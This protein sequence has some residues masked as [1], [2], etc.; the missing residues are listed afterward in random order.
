MKNAILLVAILMIAGHSYAQVTTSAM[1][2]TVLD[3]EGEA[4]IGATVV[5]IHDPSGTTYGTTT[6]DDG[7]YTLPNLRVG[8]PYT[9]QVSYIG[10]ETN[11]ASDIFLTLGEKESYDFILETEAAVLD[12]VVI[13][14]SEGTIIG[15]DRTGA[16]TNIS[17]DEI[18]KLPTISRSASDYTRLTPASDGNSFAGRNDQ[19]NNF[20]LD[21]SIF[22]N[23]F[24]LDAAAPG[25][26][27]SAQP[28]SLDAIDQ[29]SV[30]IA[31]YDIT[32]AG[33]TG[34]SVNAVTKSGTNTLT[35]TVYGYWRNQGLTG[36]KVED[37]DIPDADLDQLQAGF[38]LGGPL[39]KNKLFFFV[40]GEI[41]R[42]SDLGTTWVPSGS[43]TDGQVSRVKF[44]DMQ[45]VSD[46][47]FNR[48]GYE[49]GAF[50][51]YI[52]ETNSFKGIL[53]L[54]WAISDR[55]TLSAT[56]NFLDAS[57][58][59]PA[60]PSAIAR[61]GP[62]AQTLQMENSG[63]Q[64]NNVIH[65]GILELRSVFGNRFSNKLQVGYTAFRDSRD[66]F[67]EPFPDL[68]VLEAGTPYLVSGHEPFSIH[69]R[70]N[71]DVFQ[72]TNNFSIY[73]GDHTITVGTSVEAFMFD[74]SFNLGVYGGTF[75]P[76]YGSVQ[77]LL[78]SI[79][80]GAL[81]AAVQGARDLFEANGGD[82]GELGEGWALAETNVGQFALY[83]QDEWQATDDFTLTYGVRMDMPLFFNTADKIQ[84]NIDRNCCYDPDIVWSDE[85]GNPVQYT[86]T[87][88][89][90]QTP[91]ISP[92]IG[93]NWDVNGMGKTQLRGG[94]G[95]FT[96]RFPFV[97]IGNQVANPNFFFYNYTDRDFKFPQVWR[98]NLGVDH[99]FGKGWTATV[100]LIYTKDLQ[101]PFVQNHGLRPPT[102]TL[103]DVDNR[104]VY[105]AADRVMHFGAPVNAYVF[106]NTDLGNS[107]SAGFQVRKTWDSDFSVMIGYNYLNAMD[108]TSI[109]AEISSD[110]YDRNPALGHVNT[111]VL[112]PSLYGARHRI[113][114]SAYKTFRY[115]NE[116][117]IS[118]TISAFFQYQQGGT[119][120]DDNLA[121][122]RF[123]YVYAGDINNDGGFNNDI[124][125]IPTD[126]ELDQMNFV[127]DEQREAFRDY[128]EQDEYLSENRGEYAEKYGILAPWW[129]QWDIKIIQ[130]F[131]FGGSPRNN[132]IQI[133]FDIIN[134]GN[135]ISSSWGVKQLPNTSQPVGVSV[136][137]ATL[138][139]TYSFDPDGP[140][141]TFSPD[142]S[143]LSRWQGQLG[144]RYI[145]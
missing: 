88:L 105:T 124:M 101:A 9:I 116:K 95:F 93:F 2:G 22:N 36:Q 48:F 92:R 102:G 49:T 75:D 127:N 15:K 96:G 18:R 132:R 94:T 139:P 130:E 126:S 12:E 20:S 26:Q 80:S 34:A 47:L 138:I 13:T 70:L 58:D 81:D 122:F 143:L 65:S 68:L 98:S 51:G 78:D 41:D 76:A 14:A 17:G 131:A 97:W 32:Q 63:Y 52:H 72:F 119:T 54:D 28:I 134:F 8:G 16:E 107:F 43:S 27:T 77:A 40:N 35:G 111:P 74:N 1:K 115:G 82:E 100:D 33:F 109:E 31:P 5:A 53:K 37:Q 129:S 79:N 118:T 136:D 59:K 84:E 67:S 55:H 61:R 71:Q 140:S 133:S 120:Q 66:P 121:D 69:N 25:G 29:I 56:Y 108:A 62:D 135:L 44:S 21:G 73:T 85:D 112:A 7:G 144:L 10:Y 117:S 113:L 83:I 57:K 89:P 87:E 90:K 23:P 60:H 103:N 4:L 123:G 30:A 110:A 19:Y 6:R 142:L 50:D 99:E 3:I 46:A 141:T 11:T 38:S 91:L 42:R 104:A 24:G 114:G 125:Y 39:V 106:T 145:F 86:H 45:M 64:I 128:I 137:P